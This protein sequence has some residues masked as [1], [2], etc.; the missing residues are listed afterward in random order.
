MLDEHRRDSR[1]KLPERS[2][3]VHEEE[4]ETDED[5]SESPSTANGGNPRSRQVSEAEASG[6][7]GQQDH[8]VLPLVSEDPE[9]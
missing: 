3:T 2:M 6:P 8:I 5:S 7:Y 4:I 9:Q 1:A